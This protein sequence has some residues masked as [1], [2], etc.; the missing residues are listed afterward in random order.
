MR[1]SGAC[2]L[3]RA[4][5]SHQQ[6]NIK[7]ADQP[8]LFC[9]PDA[10][11]LTNELAYVRRDSYQVSPGHLLIIPARHVADYFDTTDEERA[12]IVELID[13]SRSWLMKEY[14]PDG[15][16][17]GVNCGR[18]AGQSVMHVHVHLIPR[19]AGDMEDPRGGVRGVIPGKQK[20]R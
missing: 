2:R 16:N 8:C 10:V 19:Y 20:Y 6:R 4:A 12:A 1:G 7:M 14:G 13:Q 9:T 18:A 15:F 11:V 3:R 17:V 5:E